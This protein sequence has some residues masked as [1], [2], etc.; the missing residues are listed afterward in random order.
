MFKSSKILII[1]IL[2]FVVF[3]SAGFLKAQAQ[4]TDI[5]GNSEVSVNKES[6]AVMKNVKVVQ[7][8]GATLYTRLIWGTSYVRLIVKTTPA[9]KIYRKYGEEALISEIKINDFIDINGELQSGS[10]SLTIIADKITDLSIL[11]K[12][13]VFTGTVS[14]IDTSAG[15]FT[16]KRKTGDTV[17]VSISD[18]T[19]IG[20]GSLTIGLDQVKIGNTITNVSGVYDYGTNTIKADKVIVYINKA[21]FLAQNYQGILKSISSTLPTTFVVT[22]GATDYTVK[23][24]GKTELLTKNRATAT[25]KRFVE[26]D[27][28]RIYGAL[29]EMIPYTTIDAEMVRNLNL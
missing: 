23:T 5:I 20:K 2:A 4:T 17:T 6:V 10:D 9:A 11:T 8:A 1:S 22:V 29:E 18:S 24:D 16:M 7:I 12:A 13:S 26:G 15:T 19:S 21:I 28:L 3:L 25:V 14:N 27:T